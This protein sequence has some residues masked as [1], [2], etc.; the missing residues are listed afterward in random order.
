[1]G[2]HYEPGTGHPAGLCTYLLGGEVAHNNNKQ[3][4]IRT[5]EQCHPNLGPVTAAGT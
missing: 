3:Y 2:Y 5:H 1:M 4:P